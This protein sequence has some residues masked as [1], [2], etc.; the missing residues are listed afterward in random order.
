MN[1][2]TLQNSPAQ[3]I[4]RPARLYYIDWLR[5]IA[6][7]AIIA[8]FLFHN[9]RFFDIDPWHVNNDETST[10]PTLFVGFINQWTMALFFVMAGASTFFA[11]R[12]RTARYYIRER[13]LR[14]LLPLVVLGWFILA[15]PQVYLERLTHS[16]FTGSFF[17][18]YANY[19]N[20]FYMDISSQGNFA[21]H[22]MHLWFLLFL[23][24]F[25]LISLPFFLPNKETG[26]SLITKLGTLFEKPWTFLVPVLLLA[27]FEGL[28]SL[29]INPGGWNFHSYLLFFIGGYLIFSNVRI[30]ENI[31]KY[32][33]AALITAV[34]LQAIQY[35][36]QYGI[37]P[38][39]PESFG[40]DAVFRI[41]V[42]L[43][44]WCWIMAIIGLGSRYL[45][46]NNRFIG[47]ASEAVLPFYILHQTIILIIGFFI[48]QWS[49]G[50][51]LKYLVIALTSFIAIMAIYELLIRRF[52]GLRF[53]FGMRTGR[54][55]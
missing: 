54:A 17:Q 5:F 47:Y 31:R 1:S 49:T 23:F 3:N 24:I 18:F 16:Q 4:T 39:I 6:I 21:W 40:T 55:N 15:P 35:V 37:R 25:S 19:F 2:S 42:T 26:K 32:A 48:V 43:R 36:L 50:I 29:G 28:L 22:G 41:L 27:V 34:V 46:F 52:N 9:S 51:A 11:L 38:D 45:N 10:L 8:I 44:S 14:L 12:T 7:I 53:L 33:F 13:F 20:G 30:Q